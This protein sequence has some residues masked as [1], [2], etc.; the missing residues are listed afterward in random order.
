MSGL[1]VVADIASSAGHTAHNAGDAQPWGMMAGERAEYYQGLTTDSTP[2]K[3][4]SQ[5]SV[6]NYPRD[7][8]SR[9]LCAEKIRLFVA[10]VSGC[11]HNVDGLGMFQ[12]S[13]GE[14]IPERD[15]GRD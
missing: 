15:L 7:P 11:G 3:D 12:G 10:G 2:P 6:A 5:L 14:V 13:T 1:Q 4:N 8:L 9:R